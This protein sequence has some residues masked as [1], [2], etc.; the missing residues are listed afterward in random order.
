MIGQLLNSKKVIYVLMALLV[1]MWGMEFIAA[2]AALDVIEP[3][4]L[5]GIKYCIGIVFLIVIKCIVDRKFPLKGRD[6]PILLI[7]ALF[8]DVLYFGTE[9][10]AM[11]YLPVSVITII[12]AFVPCLSIV[13]EIFLYKNRPTGGIVIGVLASVV[14][15]ALV[16][17]ADMEEFFQGRYLGYILAFSAVIFWN[18][19]NFMTKDLSERYSPMDLTLLQQICAIIL[20]LPYTI[21]HLPEISVVTPQVI[22]GVLYLGVIS[23]FIGFLIYVKA[24]EVIGP[25]PCALYSNFLPV[26]TTFLGWIFLKEYIS[27]T[28]L[29]GGA[30]VIA[31]GAFVIWKKGEEEEMEM[32]KGKEG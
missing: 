8:G 21:G 11:A 24:I 14:G 15:V 7:C 4:S 6:I 27:A 25:T 10:A 13:I 19:Y 22:I 2:K 1:F 18:V 26:I 31:A 5:V 20:I 9:Y 17:G 32:G 28:Q 30:I 3:F 29:L 16:I 12:L 23:A